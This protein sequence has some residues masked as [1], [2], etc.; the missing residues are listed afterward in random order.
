MVR[1]EVEYWDGTPTLI[2]LDHWATFGGKDFPEV[3]KGARQVR[4]GL[5][6][7][8]ELLHIQKGMVL[9]FDRHDEEHRLLVEG[10]EA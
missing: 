4:L 6:L 9:P 10:E 3:A 5:K 7:R 2:A 1:R 8:E